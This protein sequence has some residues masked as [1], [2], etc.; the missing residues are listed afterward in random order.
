MNKELI[1]IVDD[2]I[3][4]LSTL[5]DSIGGL[6]VLLESLD[7]RVAKIEKLLFPIMTLDKYEEKK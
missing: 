5:N 7:V 6:R 4:L 1:D 3:G 2:T